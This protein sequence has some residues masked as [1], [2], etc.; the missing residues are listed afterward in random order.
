MK[1]KE[2]K[3]KEALERNTRKYYTHLAVL[4][5]MLPGGEWYESLPQDATD[6]CMVLEEIERLK[7]LAKEYNLNFAGTKDRYDSM[8]EWS[9]ERILVWELSGTNLQKFITDASE[10]IKKYL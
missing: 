10:N 7:R 2:Q 5:K 8:L 9:A 6:R 4:L 3:R 1:S